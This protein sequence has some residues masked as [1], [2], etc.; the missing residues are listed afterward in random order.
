MKVGLVAVA[1]LIAVTATDASSAQV[2]NVSGRYRCIQ[3]C[4]GP[5]PAFVT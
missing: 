3:G 5:S 2:P 1:A 4:A